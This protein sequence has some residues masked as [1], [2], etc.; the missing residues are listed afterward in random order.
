MQDKEDED[1]FIVEG[2]ASWGAFYDMGCA[3]TYE[4]DDGCVMVMMMR[5]LL[6]M[7][8]TIS[9]QIWMDCLQRMII[10]LF[11]TETGQIVHIIQEIQ[12]QIQIQIQIHFIP[13]EPSRCL[14]KGCALCRLDWRNHLQQQ[15]KQFF[16]F[17]NEFDLIC[18]I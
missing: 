4:Y 12:I 9:L 16:Q 18:L 7:M 6:I 3:F 2:I 11:S 13:Q 15:L 14:W 8:M 17:Q 10:S 5:I 1:K